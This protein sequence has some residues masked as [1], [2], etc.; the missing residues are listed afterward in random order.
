MFSE[1]GVEVQFQYKKPLECCV[2]IPVLHISQTIK[3]CP[4]N[5]VVKF[6]TRY[7]VDAHQTMAD[8]GFALELLHFGPIGAGANVVSYGKLK[9]VTMDYVEATSVNQILIMVT[10][11]NE[12]TVRLIDFDWARKDG[13]VVYPV[14]ISPR[15]KWPTRVAGLMPIEKQMSRVTFITRL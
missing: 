11:G 6:V 10:P 2:A 3:T 14:S 9:T 7:G 5:I 8:A 15:I 4:K 13:K 12:V 1:G